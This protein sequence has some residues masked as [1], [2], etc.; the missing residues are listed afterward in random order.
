MIENS[1]FF[2]PYSNNNR[3]IEFDNEI[4]IINHIESNKK[5]IKKILLVDDEPYNIMAFTHTLESI[6]NNMV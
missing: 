3:S 6:A 4:N 2:G 1:I 5:V